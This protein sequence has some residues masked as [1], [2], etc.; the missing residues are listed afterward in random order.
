MANR[1]GQPKELPYS[2]AEEALGVKIGH[3]IPDDPKTINRANNSGI[4]AVLD[5][6]RANVCRSIA[7]LAVEVNGRHRSR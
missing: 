1:Y 5:S 6:P 4:P 7:R 3:Y 2:K